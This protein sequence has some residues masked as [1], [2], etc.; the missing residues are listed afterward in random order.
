MTPVRIGALA[1]DGDPPRSIPTSEDQREL[2]SYLVEI[3][4]GEH[5]PISDDRI[6]S[7]AEYG[8][9]GVRALRLRGMTEE[10]IERRRNPAV[11]PIKSTQADYARACQLE[12]QYTGLM[13]KH[14]AEGRFAA[15]ERVGRVWRYVMKDPE[16]HERIKAK[17]VK[18]HEEHK[19]NRRKAR[20][21]DKT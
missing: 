7:L 9:K 2:E 13:Q 14:L 19:Q 20:N 10:E 15:L 1:K 18:L 21:K 5:E 3:G 4:R 8:E 11:D 6:R 17:I 16:E 12:P